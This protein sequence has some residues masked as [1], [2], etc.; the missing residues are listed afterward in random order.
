[1]ATKKTDS[2]FSD[3]AK[4]LLCGERVKVRGLTRHLATCRKEHPAKPGKK[5]VT[6]YTLKVQGLEYPEYFL[7]L[8]MTDNLKLSDL[9]GYLRDIWLECC[10]HMSQFIIDGVYYNSAASRGGGWALEDEFDDKSMNIK[11]GKVLS[12]G[13]SFGYEYDMGSTTE[14]MIKVVAERKGLEAL[15]KKPMLLARNDPPAWVCA[16]CGVPAVKVSC[17]GFG[18][19]PSI[20]FCGKCVKKQ[21]G[22]EELFLAIV[23]SPR[24]GVCAYE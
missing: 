16:A 10:G 19:E 13:M 1:M 12:K 23:N 4:C 15:L 22:G 14:L 20:V 6:T 7:Y 21:D 24:T 2:P 17:E 8:E 18:I 11:L 5:E 3:T 9:D